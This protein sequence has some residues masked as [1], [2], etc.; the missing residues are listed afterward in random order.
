MIYS[1][2]KK[3]NLLYKIFVLVSYER[4][5]CKSSKI[6]W[7]TF[8]L[9]WDGLNV[10]RIRL[11]LRIRI[12]QNKHTLTLDNIESVKYI[13]FIQLDYVL[14]YICT[15]FSYSVRRSKSDYGLFRL[16]SCTATHCTQAAHLWDLWT[17]ELNSPSISERMQF[18][19]KKLQ[20]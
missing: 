2:K 14:M 7:I 9:I 11:R 3:M 16:H 8:E 13:F 4:L 5:K 10:L 1:K 12:T 18:S 19:V 6:S 17:K 20:G 15:H